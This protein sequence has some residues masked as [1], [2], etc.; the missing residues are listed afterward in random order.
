MVRSYKLPGDQSWYLK[1]DAEM[2]PDVSQID[3]D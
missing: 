3:V 1:D 2:D